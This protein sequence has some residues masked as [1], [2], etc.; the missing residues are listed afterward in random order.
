MSILSVTST[1]PVVDNNN[2]SFTFQA[3]EVT[4][5]TPVTITVKVTDDFGMTDT[6]VF[7]DMVSVKANIAP[8]LTDLKVNGTPIA[9]FSW[10]EIKEGT[11]QTFTLSGADD[12]DGNP[13]LLKYEAGTTSDKL[14]FTYPDPSHNG[15]ITFNA[16]AIN[17]DTP[18]DFYIRV[19][20]ELTGWTDYATGTSVV[21]K[22]NVAPD[23]AGFSFD[24]DNTGVSSS[25]HMG[26]FSKLNDY[27]IDFSGV[28][29]PDGT[30]TIVYSCTGAVDGNG[31]ID[32]SLFG[33]TTID[34]NTLKFTIG[35]IQDDIAIAFTILATDSYE[36]STPRACTATLKATTYYSIKKAGTS[37]Y[38]TI[39]DDDYKVLVFKS[40]EVLDVESIGN[41]ADVD[42]VCV[43]AGGAGGYSYS[44]AGG[45]GGYRTSYGS[46]LSGGSSATLPPL[47]LP[48]GQTTITIGAGLFN[49]NGG[50]S[51]IGSL[52]SC[53]GGGRGSDGY[54]GSTNSSSG[55][56]GGGGGMNK[57]YGGKDGTQYQG[58]QGWNDAGWSWAG[59]GGG[60]SGTIFEYEGLGG[61][62][63]TTLGV[64]GLI[65]TIIPTSLAIS[66][67]VGDVVPATH[68][69]TGNDVYFAGG[70]AG[71]ENGCNI[72]SGGWGGGGDALCI[73]SCSLT[74]RI[75]QRVGLSNT[76]GGGGGDWEYL[77][78]GV[79]GS[80]VVI[81]RYKFK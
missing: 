20:D 72:N 40:T 9:S 18:V 26:N 65:S 71:A 42:F 21:L 81:L 10:P 41:T 69:A 12:P 75:S 44:G 63:R 80:G 13:A 43:A 67:E 31:T 34:G 3:G 14:T 68:G 24:I 6:K 28:I 73:S 29:D 25:V 38:G 36:D 2:P 66:E 8:N 59:A 22:N 56:S 64:D 48:T 45:A 33:V 60:A 47:T 37:D 39:V 27:I 46:D 7:T 35:N 32:S 58:S 74:G 55:G 50:D 1:N 61:R 70:G 23:V 16:E 51:S 76:G 62:F 11:N 5:D 54:Y 78:G 53:V 52:I 77:N 4:V 15:A 19:T 49:S 57:T 30:D 79:G 17:A